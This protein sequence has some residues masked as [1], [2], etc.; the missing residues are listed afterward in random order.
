MTP[1]GGWHISGGVVVPFYVVL[2]AMFGAGINMTRR[3]P[4]IQETYRSVLP[5]QQPGFVTQTLRVNSLGA[6]RPSGHM[7]TDG[8]PA[9]TVTQAPA[10][11]A[12]S[13]VPRN[14]DAGTLNDKPTVDALRRDLIANY[15]YL[16]SAPFL[17]IAVYYL[18]LVLATEVSQP[19][20]VVMAFA[21]GLTADSI[22]AGIIGFAQKHLT[23]GGAADESDDKLDRLVQ[24]KGA[25]GD[26]IRG[27]RRGRGRPPR[28]PRPP[29]GRGRRNEGLVFPAAP[30]AGI[31]GALT[32]PE[33]APGGAAC[34]PN[35]RL[36]G[37]EFLHTPA[38]RICVRMA[39]FSRARLLV[40]QA[41]RG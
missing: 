18:L 5:T 3:V 24:Q 20:L 7:R 17:A 32:P 28:L 37:R 1:H 2:L 8:N 35:R 6:V 33:L 27:R 39:A 14:K 13:A 41:R 12:A 23:Q 22:I 29:R 36:A 34:L 19:V 10:S 16:L 40:G 21:T 30:R 31:G 4:E 26:Q 38:F 25:G 11:A 9:A 15:M